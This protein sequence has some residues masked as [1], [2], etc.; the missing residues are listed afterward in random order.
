MWGHSGKVSLCEPGREGLS[1]P[2]PFGTCRL[3]SG[4]TMMFMSPSLWDLVK[5]V[6][7][8]LMG[9]VFLCFWA[10]TGQVA[11]EPHR[12]SHQRPLMSASGHSSNG[13][14]PLGSMTDLLT[15]LAEGHWRAR[16]NESRYV[17]DVFFW[18]EFRL[19][20][21]MV[22]FGAELMRQSQVPTQNLCSR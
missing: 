17:L 8:H 6:S 21:D 20:V 10:N 15:S 14:L 13:S 16:M 22:V 7:R 1:R 2:I 18:D 12:A 4:W 11:T 9:W 3:Q 5:A 19:I